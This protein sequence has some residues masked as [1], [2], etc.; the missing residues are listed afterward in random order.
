MKAYQIGQLRHAYMLFMQ[1]NVTTQKR[2]SEMARW[3]IEPAYMSFESRALMDAAE[4]LRQGTVTNV[5]EA[6]R[7]AENN[8]GPIISGIEAKYVSTHALHT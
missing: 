7:F 4:L 6:K 3:Y 8:L 1:G 5:E 2:A